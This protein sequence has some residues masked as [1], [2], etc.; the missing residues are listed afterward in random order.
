MSLNG[1]YVQLASHAHIIIQPIP[2]QSSLHVA[3]ELVL[4][5]DHGGYSIQQGQLHGP[6]STF[7]LVN[8]YTRLFRDALDRFSRTTGVRMA[9]HTARVGAR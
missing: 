2:P 5:A 7:L 8:L 6:S 3:S 1:I 9:G 4:W